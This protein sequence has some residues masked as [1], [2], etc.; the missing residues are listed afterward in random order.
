VNLRDVQKN[1]D[2][3]AKDDPLWAVLTYP[4]KKGGRWTVEEFLSEGRREIDALVRDL[5]EIGL[6][7]VRRSAL[8]FGCGAGRLT[9]ALAKHYEQVVGVDIAPAM[10]DHAEAINQMGS[11]CR[12]V[13][14]ERSDLSAFPDG[15]FDL[16]YSNIVLQHI[17][18]GYTRRYLAEFLRLLTAEGVVVFHLPTRVRWQRIKERAP[19]AV[20]RPIRRLT[21]R[22]GPVMQM[23]GLDQ[24]DVDR[25]VR[26]HGGAV[27]D[28]QPSHEGG[29]GYP[30][31]RYVVRRSLA[32][33]S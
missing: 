6:A 9:Q 11:Q 27:A 29:E 14:N 33:S 12:F 16:I 20:L 30:G 21:G 19:E 2:E 15:S 23:Y 4:D 32:A 7:T 13:L 1:W 10:I 17:A 24:R 25:V 8:D 3:L 22:R 28:I 18:P 31:Y 26:A 5:D